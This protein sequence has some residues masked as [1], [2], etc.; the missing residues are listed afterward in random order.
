MPCVFS[1]VL[2]NPL[3]VFSHLLRLAGEAGQHPISRISVVRHGVRS[4]ASFARSKS[5][6]TIFSLTSA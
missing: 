2:G 6:S 4:P 3:V 1:S 5:V